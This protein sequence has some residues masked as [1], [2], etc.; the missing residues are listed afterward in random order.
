M[1]PEEGIGSAQC[2]KFVLQFSIH[3]CLCVCVPDQSL[4]HV[5]LFATPMDCSPPGFFVH[6]ISQARIPEWV[7]ISFCRGSS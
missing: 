4:S 2:F 7:A 6:G 3:V 1:S 5:Q